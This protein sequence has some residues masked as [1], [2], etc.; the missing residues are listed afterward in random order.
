MNKRD[1]LKLIR[2]SQKLDTLGHFKSSDILTRRIANYYNEQSLFSNDTMYSTI[3][4]KDVEDEYEDNER[5]YY[6]NKPNLR[7]PEYFD[8]GG[9]A[10]GANI[11]GLLN[12]P[13]SVPGPAAIDP[14]NLASSPSMAGGDLSSFTWEE[15]YENVPPEQ[16]RIPRR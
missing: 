2:I 9:E 15:S 1:L 16:R 4:Y 10:D 8:L 3:P 6:K 14:G 12:G 5:L 13:D 11:E 7:V